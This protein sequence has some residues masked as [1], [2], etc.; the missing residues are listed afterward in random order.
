MSKESLPS[1]RI[2][3]Y[4]I[5]VPIIQGG[6]SVRI[7]GAELVT[8]VTKCG[9]AGTIGGVG[10]G[11]GRKEY[12]NYSVYEADR[13]ALRDELRKAKEIDP[14]GVYGVNLL[15]AVT[16]YD[17]LVREAA[18][19]G[20]K[21]IVSGAGLPTNLPGLT[22]D[23]PEIALIPIVSSLQALRV[24]CLQWERK[25]HRQ[26]DAIVIE[27][28]ATA[29]GHLGVTA[30][31]GVWDE[32]LKLINVLP[33]SRRYLEE[34]NLNIPL[35][36]AG[37]IWDRSDIDRMLALG[38][39][40]VQMATRFVCTPECEAPPQFKQK[41]IDSIPEDIVIIQSPVGIPGRAIRTRFLD[42]VERGEIDDQ[43]SISCLRSC[44]FRD[45]GEKYC[46]IK[47]LGNA[48]AG[49]VENGIVFCGSNAYRSKEQR[50]VSVRQ[51]FNE[52]TGE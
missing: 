4:E 50:I 34:H 45:T 11:F 10:R 28:P 18:N 8:A 43:C 51:I 17:R 25:Y 37:G 42:K 13:M 36:A 35:I 33:E 9:G 52:L 21:F 44:C 16:D 41:Y 32:N 23:H 49:D 6:M 15:V 46:I 5:R 1:L 47:A 19:S 22:A 30:K 40:G 2:G 26:P 27:E 24:I 20:V 29:G 48:R 14:Y 38:A 3:D 31:Q 39:N 12:E 7:S